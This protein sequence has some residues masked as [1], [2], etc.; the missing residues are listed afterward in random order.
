MECDA[1]VAMLPI[2]PNRCSPKIHQKV[3]RAEKS[4]KTNSR[5]RLAIDRR[6]TIKKRVYMIEMEKKRKDEGKKTNIIEHA[7]KKM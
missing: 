3:V 2:L 4:E 7:H 1:E 6:H 5:V